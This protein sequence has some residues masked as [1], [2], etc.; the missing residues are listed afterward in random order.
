MK[1][2]RSR[3]RNVAGWSRPGAASVQCRARTRHSTR[4]PDATAVRARDSAATDENDLHAPPALLA[5]EGEGVAE[6]HRQK[7]RRCR[8]R[9]RQQHQPGPDLHQGAQRR[10]S[11]ARPRGAR[12]RQRGDD[13]ERR[14]PHVVARERHMEEQ[15][16]ARRPHRR[17]RAGSRPD[18]SRAREGDQDQ[19]VGG[20]RDRHERLERMPYSHQLVIDRRQRLS[21]H[22]KS[23]P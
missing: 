18:V 7:C 12:Q 19:G 16:Q 6:E 3:K 14:D 13:G 20:E 17:R 22:T 5:Q 15:R 23:V 9:D 10:E 4:S 11:T 21:N 2:R 8:R 1:G